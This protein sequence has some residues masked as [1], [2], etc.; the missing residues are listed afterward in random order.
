M[1]LQQA[2]R[3]SRAMTHLTEVNLSTEGPIIA[4][5]SQ[6][7]NSKG[8]EWGTPLDLW[9]EI[10][11]KHFPSEC[12]I[13]RNRD[14]MILDPCPGIKLLPCTRMLPWNHE[15]RHPDP[16]SW[17]GIGARFAFVNPPFS[18][19]NE[20]IASAKQFA[21]FGGYAVMLL[22]IRSDRPWWRMAIE[23]QR[24]EISDRVQYVDQKTQKPAGAVSFPSVLIKFLPYLPKPSAPELW[25]PNC[26]KARALKGKR[27]EWHEIAKHVVDL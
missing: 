24:V 5:A 4:E 7:E 6:G 25:W 8:D 16:T 23:G 18:N 13:D 3:G 2:G 19:V 27:G 1:H 20:W 14:G 10:L 15:R 26:H 11:L 12:W 21:Y 22:P 17:L 9:H